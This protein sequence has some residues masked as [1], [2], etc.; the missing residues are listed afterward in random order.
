MK[1]Q[2]KKARTRYESVLFSRKPKTL[3]PLSHISVTDRLTSIQ[4][5]F[6]CLETTAPKLSS[7]R[8]IQRYE[9]RSI[10]PLQMNRKV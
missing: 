5:V 10:M 8:E 9:Y 3:S 1:G 2:G 4:D 6:L 7:N